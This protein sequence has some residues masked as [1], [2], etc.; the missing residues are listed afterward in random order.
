MSTNTIEYRFEN[1]PSE[2]ISRLLFDKRDYELIRIVNNIC[3]RRRDLD[4]VRREYYGYFHPRGI[5]EMA[6]SRSLRIAYA[7]AG[8]LTSFEVGGMDERLSSLRFL[9]EEVLGTAEGSLPKNTSRALMQIMK[10]VVRARGNQRRQL[11]LAHDFRIT[12]SGKPRIVRN[13]LRKYY[14]LEMPEEWNQI[15]FD[16]HVHDANTKGRKSSTHLIMDAW[17]KGIRRLRIVHYNFIE[18][19]FAAELLEAAEIMDIDIRI[20]IEYYVPYKKKYIN[21][22]W[23]PRG[24]A[25]SQAFLCFLE[26]PVLKELMA[27]GRQVSSYQQKHVMALFRSF[28]QNQLDYL[29]KE[30][31]I[32]LKPLDENEFIRFVGIGQKSI[33]HL[34][35]FLHKKIMEFLTRR[36]ESLQAV[37]ESSEPDEKEKISE[38]FNQMNLLDVEKIA[39]ACFSLANHPGLPDPEIPRNE[40]DVPKLLQYSAFELLTRLA[41]IQSGHRITLN[42]SNLEVEEVLELIYDCNGMISRLEL[43]NLK[44]WTAGKRGHLPAISRL[45]EAINAQNPIA[46]K[47]II[48]D[49]IQMIERKNPPDRLAIIEKMFMILHDI[50]SLQSMYKGK[51][52]KARI[53]SDSTGRISGS[54]GMGLAVVETLGR[55]AMKQII[56]RDLSTHG[57]LPIRINVCKRFT[58]LPSKNRAK[59]FQAFQRLAEF[60]GNP[61]I[62][63]AIK[64]EWAVHEDVARMTDEGNVVALGGIN[65]H[66]SNDLHLHNR[67]DK[68]K[69][70]KI[71]WAYFNSHL[72]NAVKVIAGFVPAFLTFALTKEWW[73]LAY[74]G[75]FIWFGITGLRNILQSI[76]GG[77]GFR[78]SP[79]LRWNAYVSWDRIADSLLYTGFSVPLLEYL[80]KTSFLEQICGITTTTHPVLLY[81]IM[82]LIN[83]VYLS[84]HNAFRGLPKGAIY[85][86]FFRSVLSIPIAILLNSFIG[87]LLSMWAIPDVNLVLQ[88]WAAIISKTASDIMAGLI[89]G[90]ADRY[91]NIN[92]R[93]RDYHKK[94]SDL[95]HV[96][97]QLELL[98]P[99][100]RTLEIFAQPAKKQTQTN[101]E[102]M[103]LERI[104]CIHALDF[105]YFWMYQ[106]RARSALKRLLEDITEEERH[107]FVSSQFTLQRQK[108][109][110]QMFIDGVLGPDFARALSFFLSNSEPYLKEIKRFA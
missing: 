14:L 62:G 85:G 38:W 88:K 54:H 15:S 35:T 75:A 30:Y 18:P 94:L 109:I 8:L 23:V 60:L 65:R 74:F 32:E 95:I 101:M 1:D 27:E 45:Q 17:I 24:F 22:V 106:P 26:E 58:L 6:E 93:S 87:G 108:E 16:D 34:E 7:M 56:K 20:G 64:V 78:R 2:H 52:L 102:V 21:L 63:H 3:E 83:G 97:S 92:I 81:T 82:A 73:V 41:K 59:S 107:I 50:D 68:K 110:C 67:Q 57:I 47:R 48:L 100:K 28:N 42:L 37:Y 29:K 4:Y 105:L 19:R 86:N 53:G 33:L 98:F 31:G 72:R 104:I 71:P 55:R 49:T 11:K 40:P 77:G 9:R 80:V 66:V 12:A 44:D 90:L 61:V 25:D 43:L 96:Y 13:Q 76:L 99:E 70:N 10:E 69:N 46:L 39:A 84:S 103:D 89:E 51:Y 36:A 91:R 79:L 5:K